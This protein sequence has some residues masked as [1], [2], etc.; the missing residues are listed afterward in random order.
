MDVY[1]ISLQEVGKSD[2]PVHILAK[3]IDRFED[4]HLIYLFA[5]VFGDFLNLFPSFNILHLPVNII[6][7]R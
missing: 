2:P 4:S 1:I 3:D 7:Q 6:N 5:K